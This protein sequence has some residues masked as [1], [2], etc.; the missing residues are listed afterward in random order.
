MLS[1]VVGTDQRAH[2]IKVTKSL[3]PGM[4]ANAI[5]AIKAW[6]FQPGTR[7]GKPVPVRA[8]IQVNFKL[9]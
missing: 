5:T 1:I 7:K 8:I 2:D 3:D 4:D 9:R 6:Q